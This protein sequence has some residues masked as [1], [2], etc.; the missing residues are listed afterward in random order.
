MYDSFRYWIYVYTN[1]LSIKDKVSEDKG[2]CTEK[3]NTIYLY[4]NI[5][6]NAYFF[7]LSKALCRCFVTGLGNKILSPRLHYTYRYFIL[8]QGRILQHLSI[9]STRQCQ[10][11]RLNSRGCN[12]SGSYITIILYF[13]NTDISYILHTRVYRQALYYGQYTNIIYNV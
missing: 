3:P 10:R 11:N 5:S 1:I 13:Y 7:F 12:C 9:C 6:T 8:L 2:T 4:T